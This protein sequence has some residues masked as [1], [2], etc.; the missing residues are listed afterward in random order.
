[1]PPSKVLK[2]HSS[3]S[4]KPRDSP[5]APNHEA[6]HVNDTSHELGI[7]GIHKITDSGLA[8]DD[9][10]KVV[11]SSPPSKVL[12]LLDKVELHKTKSSQASNTDEDVGSSDGAVDENVAQH[13][14]VASPDRIFAQVIG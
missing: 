7:D 4:S 12:E 3:K 14:A 10:H 6:S 13:V 5:A 11:N 1:M 8:P 9:D 2:L